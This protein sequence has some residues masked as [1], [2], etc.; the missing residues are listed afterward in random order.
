MKVGD[1]SRFCSAASVTGGRTRPAARP[2]AWSAWACDVFH[3]PE[4]LTQIKAAAGAAATALTG[5]TD[6]R[7]ALA[8]L[9]EICEQAAQAR[10]PLKTALGGRKA[11]TVRSGG[12]RDKVLAHLD[13]HPGSELTPHEIHKVLGHSSGGSPTPWTPW[14]SSAKPS[15]P[16]TSYAGS[17]APPPTRPHPPRGRPARAA[18]RAAR[19][20]RVPREHP[21]RGPG[22]HP[23]AP[24]P[25][26]PGTPPPSH[27]SGSRCGP[28]CSTS[29]APPSC[30]S[31]RLVFLPGEEGLTP[32]AGAR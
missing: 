11:P 22:R 30:G 24:A 32:A 15:W 26:R 6:L 14:S 8:G 28:G 23:A 29:P 7:A 4:R 10:R 19:N 16:P 17:A 13:A 25:R 31:L 20:W 9:D 3:G 5:D 2:S 1:Q 18:P 12:L 27:S 21:Q